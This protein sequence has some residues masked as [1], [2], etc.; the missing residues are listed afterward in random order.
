PIMAR[1]G[2][3]RMGVKRIAAPLPEPARSSMIAEDG[4]LAATRTLVAEMASFYDDLRHLRDVPLALPDV[5]VSVISGLVTSRAE[6]GYRPQLIAAHRA[7]AAA[8]PRGRH[9]EAARSGH[10]VP[11]SEPDLVVEEINRILDTISPQ[12]QTTE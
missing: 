4:T 9:V 2:L 5:P 6:R 12:E 3:V 8:L 11:L 7:C 10:H 1:V